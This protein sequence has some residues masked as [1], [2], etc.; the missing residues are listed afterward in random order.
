VLASD[1][2]AL[3]ATLQAAWQSARQLLLQPPMNAR[4]SLPP[5]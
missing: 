4:I 3:R 1:A 2:V 5:A